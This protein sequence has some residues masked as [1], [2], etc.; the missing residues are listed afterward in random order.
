M[1]QKKEKFTTQYV[2]MKKFMLTKPE[3]R[4]SFCKTK[5]NF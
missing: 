3:F 4:C 2:N 5:V 1:E